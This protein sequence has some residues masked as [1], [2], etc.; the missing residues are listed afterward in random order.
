MTAKGFAPLGT[1]LILL[2]SHNSSHAALVSDLLIT[3]VMPNPAAVSDSNGEWFE[4]FNPTGEIIDLD[5]LILKDDGSNQYHFDGPLPISPG[6]YFILARNGNPSSNGGFT[7]NH[8][9]SNFSLGNSGDEIIFTTGLSELLRLDYGADFDAAAR[10]REL[11]S[12]PMS[13]ANYHLTLA[14]LSYGLGDIGTPGQA[15]T[16]NPS[17]AAV[18]LP[19]SIWLFISGILVVMIRDFKSMA[20]AII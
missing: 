19:P 16:F 7:P 5:G 6:A 3:E 4:L 1:V 2:L 8:V 13:S 17:L 14:S 18:P 12:L 15:G 9:Y 10:S 11:I 20:A